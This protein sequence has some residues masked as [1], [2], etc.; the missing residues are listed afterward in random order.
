MCITDKKS[1]QICSLFCC[2]CC[3]VRGTC[4]SQQ[5][6]AV[7]LQ[8]QCQ[9]TCQSLF[10]CKSFATPIVCSFFAPWCT[11]KVIW[12]VKCSKTKFKF[13]PSCS[14]D[15]AQTLDRMNACW[16]KKKS[17]CVLQGCGIARWK[18][19]FYFILLFSIKEA[20]SWLPPKSD[21]FTSLWVMFLVFAHGDVKWTANPEAGRRGRTL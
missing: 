1:I 8:F 12:A 17:N 15:F 7:V 9:C 6:Q 13:S 11:S 20:F 3:W 5:S 10:M 4:R 21:C 16:R 14:Q 2:C 18:R 19:F